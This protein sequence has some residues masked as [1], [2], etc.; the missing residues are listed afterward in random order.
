MGSMEAGPEDPMSR[1]RTQ[2]RDTQPVVRPQHWPV[3]DAEFEAAIT[4]AG[5]VR[6]EQLVDLTGPRSSWSARAVHL[7]DPD[8]GTALCKRTGLTH[9]PGKLLDLYG[10]VCRRCMA[11]LTP[12]PTG[13]EARL[14]ST[15]TP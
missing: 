11:V 6:S 8:T 13:P 9:P 12:R 4:A 1:P 3:W 2:A 5:S 7:G 14:I 10:Q 15:L